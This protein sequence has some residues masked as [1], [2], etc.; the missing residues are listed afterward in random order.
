MRTLLLLLLLALTATGL[1]AQQPPPV[2]QDKQRETLF[3]FR[4]D[5]RN[6]VPKIS[7]ATQ[8]AVLSS[9]FRKYLT[10]LNQCNSQ[11]EPRDG[12]DRLLAARNAGQIAPSILDMATGSFT[13]PGETQTAY[14]ISVS[15]CNASHAENFGTKRLAIFAGAK[16]VADLDLDFRSSIVRKTDLDG[17][18]VNELL[19]TTG[20]MNHGTVIEMAALLD[21]R[22]GRRH[23][24]A[25]FG[26]VTED[27]CPSEEAGSE[28]RASVLSMI[29]GGPG[30]LPNFR[31]ANYRTGCR[32]PT[33]WRFVGTGKMQE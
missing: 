19:M 17:D 12:V 30:K 22:N 6:A 2:T 25:D 24:I 18:G 21:F 13:A 29:G 10:D 8:R 26:F 14:V 28:A 7:P 20:D 9:I 23:V 27:S 31:I 16:L 15:E 3:D 33:R 4:V 32:K 5:R 1:V 11:W